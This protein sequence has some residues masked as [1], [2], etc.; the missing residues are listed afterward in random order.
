M[1]RPVDSFGDIYI[2]F[3]P[4][5][6]VFSGWVGDQDPT[7]EGLENALRNMFHSAWRN[8]VGFGSD[9]GGYRCCGNGT[10]GRTTELLLR[11]AQVK[12]QIVIV[13]IKY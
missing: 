7:F 3:S 8:Y 9:I 12:R 1:S 4:R 10:L 5:D 11:W 2:S 13:L 6:V